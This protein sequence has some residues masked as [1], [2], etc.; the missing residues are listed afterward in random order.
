MTWLLRVSSLTPEGVTQAPPSTWYELSLCLSRSAQ[1]DYFLNSLW[2]PHIIT[3]SMALHRNI[4]I[5]D[6]YIISYWEHVLKSDN[7]RPKGSMP[8]MRSGQVIRFLH[9]PC[10]KANH[11]SSELEHTWVVS[12]GDGSKPPW[13]RIH[14]KTCSVH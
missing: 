14:T 7:W 2:L 3:D 8:V 6:M 9:P 13:L 5:F 12:S 4:F 11:T 10:S 1:K